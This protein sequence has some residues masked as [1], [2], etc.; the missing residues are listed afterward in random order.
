M[1][2]YITK[3]ES[4]YIK[5]QALKIGYDKITLLARKIGYRPCHVTD[6]LNGKRPYTKGVHNALK[7]IGI[8]VD[9]VDGKQEDIYQYS[10][11]LKNKLSLCQK[12]NANLKN[13]VKLLTKELKIRLYKN[14]EEKYFTINTNKEIFSLSNDDYKKLKEVL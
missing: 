5:A 11:N 9:N 14:E 4:D 3:E 10:T 1:L 12:E 2:R 13:A 8:N 6:M 7:E